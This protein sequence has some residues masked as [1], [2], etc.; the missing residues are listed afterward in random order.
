MISGRMKVASTISE[1]IPESRGKARSFL[2][3]MRIP[4]LVLKRLDAPANAFKHSIQV[5][6]S[7]E[8]KIVKPMRYRQGAGPRDPGVSRGC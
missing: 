7:T 3:A 1:I 8:M 4:Q 6:N 2:S 5:D